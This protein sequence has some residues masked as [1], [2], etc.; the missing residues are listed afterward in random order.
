[1]TPQGTAAG[2]SAT[3]YLSG[4]ARTFERVEITDAKG[5]VFPID[6]GIARIVELVLSLRDGGKA[7]LIGN[8]GSAAIVSHMHNDLCKAV[9]VRAVVFN[10]AP[11]LTAL[12]NDD[13]YQTVFHRPV[14]LW[15]DAGDLLIAVSS[16][17][18]SENIVKAATLAAE[19]GCRV[20]TF[21]GFTPANRLRQIG[22]LN[23][24]VPDP[25][26]GY[27]EMTHSVVGHCITDFAVAKTKAAAG[28]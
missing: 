19:K 17:G 9:G 25:T 27:V 21:T 22:H 24:Y 7:L 2:L 3:G 28:R 18:E 23:V 12:A 5:T 10:E 11:F 1:M 6:D 15:A 13:G 20:L 14:G 8:G 4:L 16:S 26:Y